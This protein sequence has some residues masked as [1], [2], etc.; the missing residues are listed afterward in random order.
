MDTA[1]ISAVS[2]LG[3]SVV[4]GLTAGITTWM[5]LRSQARAGHRLHHITQREAL[6]SDFI[7]AASESFSN[8][9]LSSEPQSH[10]LVVM[11]S[12]VGRMRIISS[13]DVVACAEKTIESIL[14]TYLSP[15][16]SVAEIRGA[17]RSGELA[18][19]L[20]TFSESARRELE[21]G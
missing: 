5:S 1:F 4:G 10:E 20:R 15:N 6:Y 2:A 16:R 11:Y 14:E 7:I 12:M 21:I 17:M 9:I 18:D 3:G 19:P 8:A 13:T